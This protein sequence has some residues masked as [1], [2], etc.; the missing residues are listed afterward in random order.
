MQAQVRAFVAALLLGVL[1]GVLYDCVRIF[2][3]LLGARNAPVAPWAARLRLPALPADFATRGKVRL[4]RT[5]AVILFVSEFLYALACGA[6]S[7][8]FVYVQNDGVLRF[9]FLACAVV[10]FF[11]YHLSIGRLVMA[12]AGVVAFFLRVVFFYLLLALFVPMRFVCRLAARC[13]GAAGWFF[14][15][16]IYDRCCR[17]RKARFGIRARYIV[18]KM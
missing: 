8:L 18:E 14:F 7:M 1:Y 5:S 17:R 15:L 12:V 2:L 3:V 4:P 10:G 11:A 6:L 13:L 16:P 9:Y